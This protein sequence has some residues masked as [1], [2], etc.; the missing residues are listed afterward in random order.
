MEPSETREAKQLREEN[1]KL[2]QLA[3]DMSLDK[4]MLQD[5]FKKNLAASATSQLSDTPGIC[6]MIENYRSRKLTELWLRRGRL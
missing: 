2:K 6:G 4:A 3:A 1:I 5:V